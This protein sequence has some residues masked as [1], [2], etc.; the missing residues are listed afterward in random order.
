MPTVIHAVQSIA[1]TFNLQYLLVSVV[2]Q[3]L[4]TSSSS[5]SRHFY[6]LFYLSFNSVF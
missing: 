5:F 1:S 2:I 4:L 3:Y 6:S